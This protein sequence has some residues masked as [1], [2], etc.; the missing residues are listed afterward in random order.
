MA[1][2]GAGLLRNAA[3][4]RVALFRR[5][6]VHVTAPRNHQ[7]AF[8]HFITAF[9]MPFNLCNFLCGVIGSVLLLAALYQSMGKELIM[10]M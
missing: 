4:D 7:H 6:S 10:N 5:G 9:N 8:V 3:A 2:D 1:A